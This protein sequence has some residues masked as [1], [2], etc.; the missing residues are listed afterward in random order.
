MN[1]LEGLPLGC[2]PPLRKTL[3]LEQNATPGADLPSS[4]FKIGK[5]N[6]P[7][8]WVLI[9]DRP[10]ECLSLYNPWPNPSKVKIHNFGIFWPIFDQ[11]GSRWGFLRLRNRLEPITI[12]KSYQKYEKNV[13][14][15]IFWTKNRCLK[16][17]PSLGRRC[18][19][20]GRVRWSDLPKIISLD[21]K[22]KCID[23]KVFKNCS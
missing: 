8:S 13:K 6:T 17:S 21:T 14:N 20:W 11:K 3:P 18:W 23:F 9:V 16:Y 10:Y 7:T 1:Q 5:L 2:T 19:R 15:D 12:R 22:L 4:N